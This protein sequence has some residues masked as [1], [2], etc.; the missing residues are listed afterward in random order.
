LKGSSQDPLNLEWTQNAVRAL[1]V[2]VSYNNK[3]NIQHNFEVT[4]EKMKTAFCIWKDRQL[5]I[6]GRNLIAKS[7]GISK[8]VYVASMLPVPNGIIAEADKIIRNYIWKDK[9]SNIKRWALINDY[10][11]GGLKAPDVLC[12]VKALRLAWLS[13]L[14]NNMHAHWKLYPESKF[15]KYGGLKFLLHCNITGKSIKGL[16]KFY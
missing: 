13:R 15:Q 14:L 4:L 11:N 8:L 3:E 12:K 7:M 5:T 10:E 9:K 16:P 6:L 2:Y 1:G